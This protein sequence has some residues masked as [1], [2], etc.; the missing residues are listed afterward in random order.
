MK[1]FGLCVF[2]CLLFLVFRAHAQLPPTQCVTTVAAGGTGDQIQFPQIPCWPTTTLVIMKV[3]AANTTTTPAISVNGGS[4]QT[5][6]NYDGT[7]IPAGTFQPGQYRILAYNGTNWLALSAGVVFNVNG[8]VVTPTNA[9]LKTI[10]GTNG[11]IVYRAGFNSVGDGGGATYTFATSNCMIP[12]GDNGSE[13]QPTIGT[14]CWNVSPPASGLSTA[15]WGGKGDGVTNDAVAD[16]AA[17]T[18]AG[19][20]GG[21]L[22]IPPNWLS[23]IGSATLSDNGLPIIIHGNNP[24]NGHNTDTCTSGF[25]N[26]A[27]TAPANTIELNISGSGTKIDHLCIVGGFHTTPATAGDAIYVHNASDVSLSFNN[28]KWAAN[29]IVVDATNSPILDNNWIVGPQQDGIAMGPASTGASPNAVQITNNRVICDSTFVGTHG[30]ALYAASVI[31]YHGNTVANCHDGFAIIPGANQTVLGQFHDILG[32]TDIDH[33]V[34]IQP[35]SVTAQVIYAHFTNWWAGA[36]TNATNS[37]ILIDGTTAAALDNIS[38]VGGVVHGSLPSSGLGYR[39]FDIEGC[40]TGL[41]INGNTIAADGNGM[42]DTGIYDNNQ[43]DGTVINGN[44]F[45]PNQGALL[46]GLNVPATAIG[47]DLTFEGNNLHTAVT[48]I[49]W[50]PTTVNFRADLSGGFPLATNTAAVASA[51]SIVVDPSATHAVL[52]GTTNISNISPWWQIRNI[53]FLLG[54]GAL[55]FVTGGGTGGIC[56]GLT[57][58]NGEIVNASWNA[59]GSCWNLK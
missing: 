16:Q 38:F 53:Q 43:C 1:K 9:T 25:T 6:T 31:S 26:L 4:F 18:W 24:I 17:F 11:E 19:T 30:I 50:G 34:L 49:I 45:V 13:V 40:V 29:G 59:S 22:Q 23:Y 15:V 58:T 35:T 32:D 36:N 44:N 7:A 27:G 37:A 51:A 47:D 33:E 54:G 20:V 2:I 14:G 48:P 46:V 57:G 42:L 41:I 28:I 52:S 10:V 3:A 21:T 12:G 39:L 55:N 56:V 5:I 8:F